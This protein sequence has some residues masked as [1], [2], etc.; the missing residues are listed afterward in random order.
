MQQQRKPTADNREK[1]DNHERG[2]PQAPE[3]FSQRIRSRNDG[4]NDRNRK[5]D[6][7]RDDK[8]SAHGLS[9]RYTSNIILPHRKALTQSAFSQI[10]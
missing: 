8:Q 3:R 7:N 2:H 5:R 10:P 1:Q 4:Q 6:E 9:P